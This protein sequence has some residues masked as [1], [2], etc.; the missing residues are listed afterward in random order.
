MKSVYITTSVE[1]LLAQPGLEIHHPYSEGKG[2]LNFTRPTGF[3]TVLDATT[4]RVS[5]WSSPFLCY[6]RKSQP[7]LIFT[8]IFTLPIFPH[9]SGHSTHSA[10]SWEK[11]TGP[12][13]WPLG[14]HFNLKMGTVTISEMSVIQATCT[15]C[16]YPEKGSTF[17]V[18]CPSFFLIKWSYLQILQEYV[19]CS[20]QLHGNNFEDLY[21]M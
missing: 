20:P 17:V 5:I 10:P 4:P 9:H 16:Y 19:V 18:L 1:K 8:S 12:F 14:G 3:T 11:V 15:Q 21:F 2:N 7:L 13:H 6:P